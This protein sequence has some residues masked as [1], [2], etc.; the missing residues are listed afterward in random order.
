MDQKYNALADHVIGLVGG[1]ENI[2]SFTHC[3]TRLRFNLKDT[4]KAKTEQIKKLEHTVGTKWAGNQLQIIIGTDVANAYKAILEKNNM[5]ELTSSGNAPAT[6]GKKKFRPQAV[7]EAIT[8]C[9]IPL[10]PAFMGVSLVKTLG[11]LLNFMGILSAESST[12]MMLDMVGT[13]GMY[14]MPIL[15]AYTA[16]KKFGATEVLAMALCSLMLAPSFV[17][18]VTNS[19]AMTIWGIPVYNGDYS[20]MLFPSIIV[21]FVMSY[22]EKFFKK[23]IPAVL[24]MLLVPLCTMMVMVPLM[25]CLLAP[26][27][28][29]IGAL[30]TDG[31]MFLYTKAGFLAVGLLA[32]IF[33]VLVL[34]GMHTATVPAMITC[35][36]AYGFDPIILPAM[37]LSN[38]AE[39][40]A[41]FGVAV[42]AKKGDQKSTAIGAG[43]P[44]FLAGITEP[45]LFGINLPY[46]TPLIAA[47]LGGFVGGCYVGITHTG[48][49]GA[50]GTGVLALV[51]FISE[52]AGTF[53]NGIIGVAI[54]CAVTFVAT[55][56]LF[57]NKRDATAENAASSVNDK[58][59]VT[60]KETMGPK[61][62][63][64]SNSP[65]FE[66]ASP[67]Q[68]KAISLQEVNDGVFSE[69]MMGDGMG[70]IPANEVLTAPCDAEVA[71]V[72]DTGHAIGL[73]A[74]NGIE[75]LIHVGIDTVNMGGNGFEPLVAQGQTVHKG[76]A[77][78]NFNLEKIRSAGYNPVTLIL[79]TE[80][81]KF[82][83]TN[84][85]A[86]TVDNDSI[87]FSVIQKEG[88]ND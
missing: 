87:L 43:I 41:A 33:P 2:L 35:Y 39:S 17:E 27:G 51:A 61:P 78:L 86:G 65:A 4:P 67:L 26:V 37:T 69:G 14:F 77:L 50:G 38:M 79:V 12:Y 9:V 25:F 55:L 22:V 54:T 82:D 28:L 20:N 3:V 31:I 29:W 70:I 52:D 85:N 66:I 5:Q 13:A 74:D 49:F 42:K 46:K 15:V 21:V 88:K 45:A 6:K 64:F 36:M 8:G 53:I 80:M 68:G 48:A 40:M 73:R 62:E 57:R 83:V 59:P 84:K 71:M 47:I 10:I 30:I 23:R 63:T 32:A 24:S 60:L 34:T 7:I 75:L 19:A 81:D 58:E 18:N 11:I 72:F 1:K 56:L 76:D 16:A 44:A